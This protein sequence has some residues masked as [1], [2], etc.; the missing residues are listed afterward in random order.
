L[1]KNNAFGFAVL[2][3]SVVSVNSG[4]FL[5]HKDAAKQKLIEKRLH[6]KKTCIMMICTVVLVP[7]T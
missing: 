4:G 6:P 5:Y 7:S 1:V 2:Q 3:G